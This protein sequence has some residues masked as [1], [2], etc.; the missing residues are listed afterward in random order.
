MTTS[1]KIYI[2][3]LAIGVAAL[4]W[5]KAMNSESVSN[6]Q[7]AQADPVASGPSAPATASGQLTP[8][9]LRA[10]NRIT[11]DAPR[12]LFAIDDAQAARNVFMKTDAFEQAT[13]VKTTFV[14][15]AEVL[16]S[17]KER[18]QLSS[19]LIGPD[20]AYVVIN[21]DIVRVGQNIGLFT[22]VEIAADSVVMEVEGERIRMPLSDVG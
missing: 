2:A 11:Q 20:R 14:D 6:P 18:L 1:R 13:R 3:V 5:D 16:A 10:L 4:V 17:Y 21:G 8:E 22:L 19:V 15:P 7:Q 12:R 9:V